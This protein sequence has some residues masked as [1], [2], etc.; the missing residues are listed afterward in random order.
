MRAHPRR[1]TT[2]GRHRTSQLF[3]RE[4]PRRWAD[5]GKDFVTNGRGACRNMKIKH[6]CRNDT[7]A[8]DKKLKIACISIFMWNW[9]L[10]YEKIPHVHALCRLPPAKK[11]GMRAAQKR[12][13]SHRP[14]SPVTYAACLV[15]QNTYT[16]K[17]PARSYEKTHCRCTNDDNNMRKPRAPFADMW[18]PA[19]LTPVTRV[20]L[21]QKYICRKTLREQTTVCMV[22][23]VWVRIVTRRN[24]RLLQHVQ[25][26]VVLYKR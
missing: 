4:T 19:N 20:R 7:Y 26:T 14:S 21:F 5:L 9:K 24:M 2:V 22:C 3:Q 13:H 8:T 6:P 25:T 12:M 15:F 18:S 17:R 16:K 11:K 10:V 23:A 1:C